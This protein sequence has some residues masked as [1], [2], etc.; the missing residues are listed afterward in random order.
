MRS[1]ISPVS[2]PLP[3]SRSALLT[4]SVPSPS[5]CRSRAILMRSNDSSGMEILPDL[6]RCGIEYSLKYR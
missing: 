5:L 4:D 1:L 2:G 3:P 6:R